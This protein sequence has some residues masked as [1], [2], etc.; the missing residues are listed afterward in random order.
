MTFVDNYLLRPIP[1]FQ[2]LAARYIEEIRVIRPNFG[3]V[4]LYFLMCLFLLLPRKQLS[5]K[6]WESD[7]LLSCAFL[8]GFIMPL[9]MMNQIFIRLLFF[10]L[11]ISF[12]STAIIVSPT[13]YFRD[14]HD[15]QQ[16]SR[17]TVSNNYFGAVKIG[18]IR[19]SSSIYLFAIICVAFGWFTM[20]YLR[21]EYGFDIVRLLG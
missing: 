8:G 19:I 14:L 10:G 5:H 13:A 3:Y 11:F 17:T 7:Y 20:I 9:A 15:Q 12:V 6:K 2:T 16:I 18:S 21:H 1:L 4:F